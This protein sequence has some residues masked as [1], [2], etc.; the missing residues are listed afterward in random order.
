[1]LTAPGAEAAKRKPQVLVVVDPE[2]AGLAG[3]AE[4]HV[5]AFAKR[6]ESLAGW[7]P[8]SL[9]GKLFT[10]L[11]E[12]RAFIAAKKPAFALLGAHPLVVLRKEHKMAVM[13]HVGTLEK[14]R[15]GYSLLAR[16]ADPV[17]P[18]PHQQPGLRLATHIKDMQWINVIF[19][20]MLKP[21][22]HF[23]HV[24]VA[25]EREAVESVLRKEAD[26]A[27][28]WREHL[29]DYEKHLGRDG[30]LRVSFTSAQLVPPTLVAFEKS[31][32]DKDIKALTKVLPEVCKGAGNIDLCG[33]LGFLFM[34]A[35]EHQIHPHL[36]FKYDNYK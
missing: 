6:L 27:L 36:F 9:E 31:A 20:G 34:A 25:T 30:G 23:K 5:D 1:M 4:Q 28:V 18:A 17:G 2:L 14:K 8:G 13:G 32:K 26:V 12:A 11:E 15:Y 22:T 21:A 10:N 24:P 33:E 3:S 19:D 7:K 35:G 16:T 29:R